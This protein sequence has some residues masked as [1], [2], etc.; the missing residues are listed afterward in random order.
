MARGRRNQGEK[1]KSANK[2]YYPLKEVNSKIAQNKYDIT[3]K[4]LAEA[5]RDFGWVKKDIANSL[6]KLRRNQC[7]KTERSIKSPMVMF[8]VY[9]T[10]C[11]YEVRIPA[12][13]VRCDKSH[14]AAA[15]ENLEKGA[16]ELINTACLNVHQYAG[17][18]VDSY[19]L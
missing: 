12:V 10:H 16:E 13:V 5:Q 4:A 9:Q 17:G 11:L 7:H 19:S 14:I 2:P 15:F 6:K 3:N 18:T 1:A 8:D